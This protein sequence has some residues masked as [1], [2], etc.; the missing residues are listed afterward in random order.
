MRLLTY[1]HSIAVP[2]DQAF[3]WFVNL[4]KNYINWHPVTH[5]NFQWLSEKPVMKGSIFTFEEQIEGHS[6]KMVMEISDFIENQRISFSSIQIYAELKY[7]LKKS[8]G[9]I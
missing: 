6:H 5:K 7:P 8:Q 3:D 4:E 2:V 1:K 9:E